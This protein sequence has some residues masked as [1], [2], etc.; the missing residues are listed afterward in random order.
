MRKERSLEECLKEIDTISHYQGAEYTELRE[1]LGDDV[2]RKRLSRQLDLYHSHRTGNGEGGLRWQKRIM[3]ETLRL[4]LTCTGLLQRARQNARRPVVVERSVILSRLPEAFDGFRIL[5]L[6]DFHFEFIPELPELL[7][8]LLETLS[9]DLCVL[10]GDFRGETT[11]PYEESLEHLARCRKPMG[12]EV[13]AVLGNHDNVELLPRLDRLGI[14][15]LMNELCPIDRDGTSLLMVGVDDPQYYQTHDLTFC[16]AEVAAA[17]VSV[18]LSHTP[19]ICR[20]AAEAGFDLMLSGHTHGGQICL[21]GGIPVMGH[22]GTAP[23]ACIRGEWRMNHLQG[24]T[25]TGVGCSSI[26]V[27]LNCPPEVTVHTLKA[28]GT[29]APRPGWQARNC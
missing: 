9:F 16:R 15:C 7:N 23:R 25:S 12:P 5:H 2:L 14:R 20:E 11:G 18:L 22:I 29:G 3:R 17:P 19:A 27:R 8:R 10:T 28:T 4:G 13:L 24:Y 1:K 6:S 26:D 21:P